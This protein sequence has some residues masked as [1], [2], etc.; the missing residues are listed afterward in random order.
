MTTFGPLWHL[1]VQTMVI[2]ELLH[3]DLPP[4]FLVPRGKAVILTFLYPQNTLSQLPEYNQWVH[5][6]H[7]KQL[8]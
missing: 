7:Q 2:G 3:I 5:G 8:I 4:F 1:E 6:T